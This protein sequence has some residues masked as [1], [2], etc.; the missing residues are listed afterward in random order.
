MHDTPRDTPRL[1][2]VDK[3]YLRR[4]TL[5]YL[6]R[7]ASSV[8]NLRRVL[9]RKAQRRLGQEQE[10]PPDLA[11]Q[12]DEVIAEAMRMDL[13]DDRRFAEARMTTLLRRG[14]SKQ[15]LKA[16]LAAKG[17]A[18]DVI[19]T[20]IASADVDDLASARRL[21][22]RRR[23][24]IWRVPQDDTRRE[25]DMGVLMRSGFSYSTARAA[26]EPSDDG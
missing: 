17:V 2:P 23:L 25:R 11:A 8:D 22:Q 24:G 14:T 19:E 12:I 15:G 5:A 6:Q 1:K 9:Q 21:A 16:R 3:A 20:T 7:Y 10:P 18:R 26:L 4:A 13:V